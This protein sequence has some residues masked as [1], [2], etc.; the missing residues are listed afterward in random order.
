[1][2]VGA[3]LEPTRSPSESNMSPAVLISPAATRTP[4]TARTRGRVAALKLGVSPLSCSTTSRALITT[5]VLRSE[6]SKIS[7]KA[8]KVVSVRM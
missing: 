8:A 5:S 6:S 3:N 2:N 7:S 4:R 1:M